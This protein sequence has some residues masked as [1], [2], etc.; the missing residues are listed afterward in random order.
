MALDATMA[1]ALGTWALYAAFVI[2]RYGLGWRGRRTAQLA[3][4]GFLLVLVLRLV[5]TP[6]GHF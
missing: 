5:I 3:I 4:A 2:L 1:V 6:I